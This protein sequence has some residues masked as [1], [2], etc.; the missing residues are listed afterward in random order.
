MRIDKLTSKFQLA[1]SDAQSLA[2]GRDHQFIEPQHVLHAQLNQEGSS[3]RP[4]LQQAGVN[5][6]GLRSELSKA[7]DQLPKVEG[8]GGDVQ[9]S[10]ALIQLLN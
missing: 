6:A 3:L 4:I 10:Q 9:L 5:L 7:L 1:L 2:L 8:V